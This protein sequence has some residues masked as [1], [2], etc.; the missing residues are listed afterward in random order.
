[1]IKTL[2]ARVTLWYLAFFS[3]LFLLFSLFLHG[4]VAQRVRAAARR[5]ALRAGRHRGGAASR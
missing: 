1:M 4:V 5:I 3:L 2:R